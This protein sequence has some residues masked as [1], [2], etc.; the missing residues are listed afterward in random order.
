[1][2]SR[3]HPGVRATG[4]GRFA[5]STA[6]A[7]RQLPLVFESS[8]PAGVRRRDRV[9]RRS[10]LIADVSAALLVVVGAEL[11]LASSGP[12]AG[13][14]V[15]VALFPCVSTA[16]GLYRRDES[17]LSTNTLDEA[18]A[19][20]QAATLSVVLSFLVASAT[21][22]DPLGGTYVAMSLAGLTALTL[23]LRAVARSA[24]RHYTPS[25][26][27]L[28]V[29][30]P[31]AA[32]HLASR[33]RTAPAVKAEVI[34]HWPLERLNGAADALRGFQQTLLDTRAQRVVIAGD[35]APAERVHE[36]IQVAKALGVKVSLLPSTF[37]VVGSSVAFDYLGGLTLLGVRPIGFSRRAHAV[38]RALDRVASAGLLLALSPLLA[39]IALA[40]RLTSPG[41][42]LFRQIRVGRD[43]RRFKMLKF[44]S[45][46]A[47][48][49]AR[50]AAL[51][52]LNEAEGLFKIQ[53][54]PRITPRRRAAAPDLAWTSCRS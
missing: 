43:G 26:R 19:L 23:A 14:F 1:M 28:V 40:I 32:S 39:V 7:R 37:D 36:T 22:S 46:V 35:G 50:K 54:D 15:L 6:V 51:R 27:C 11:A 42:V 9:F 33:L 12:R 4:R 53:S 17:V 21:L 44:R 29:G 16:A 45:M 10:L 2:Q 18:P 48:A 30:E 41:P 49:E 34:G 5:R 24:A 47:D 13:A 31:D 3:E 20:F 52:A 25:E 38:K 8:V